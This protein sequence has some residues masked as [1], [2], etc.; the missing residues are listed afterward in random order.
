M[1]TTQDISIR[2]GNSGTVGETRN[3]LGLVV[4]LLVGLAGAEVPF[5]LTGQTVVF[6]VLQ[7]ATQVLRKDSLTGGITLTNGTDRNGAIAAVPNKITVPISVIESR[8]LEASGTG[9]TY[10]LERRQGG[11]Q[12]TML[13]GNV[14]IEAGSNDD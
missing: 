3:D 1:T 7:G 6:R 11:T 9:L 12:R 13:T 4:N 14:F 10:D 5:D 8:T 2:A